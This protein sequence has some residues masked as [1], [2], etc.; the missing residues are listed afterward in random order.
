M[1]RIDAHHHVWELARR[2]HGWLGG[3][4]MAAIRQDFTLAELAGSGA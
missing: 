2:P 3:P 4:A 1:I